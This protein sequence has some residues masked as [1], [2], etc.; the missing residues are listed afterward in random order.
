MS[1]GVS[2]D[3]KNTRKMFQNLMRL[4]EHDARRAS[5]AALATGFLQPRPAKSRV[6][7][8]ARSNT[9]YLSI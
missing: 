2:L 1:G 9:V 5:S 8:E 7:I 6:E 4:T 3:I